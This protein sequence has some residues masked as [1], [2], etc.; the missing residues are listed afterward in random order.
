MDPVLLSY[1]LN[2]AGS[3]LSGRKNRQAQSEIFNTRMAD[4]QRKFSAGM[5]ALTFAMSPQGP[6]GVQQQN[7][8]SA[9]GL[10]QAEQDRRAREAAARQEI[11]RQAIQKAGIENFNK[12]VAGEVSK[13]RSRF[14]AAFADSTARGDQQLGKGV[15]GRLSKTFTKSVKKQTKGVANAYDRSAGQNS[16]I[17]GTVGG[18]SDVFKQVGAS[19]DQLAMLGVTDANARRHAY[20]Q[21]QLAALSGRN[22]MNIANIGTRAAG[23]IRPSPLT[24]INPNSNI[25]D[26]LSGVGNGLMFMALN[27]Y[28]PKWVQALGRGQ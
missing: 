25:G 23:T 7:M 4:Q 15:K 12:Q 17:G 3:F 2:G 14:A 6:M 24:T 28:N 13:K 5:N 8:D 21:M 9:Y 20:E 27:G 26:V 22:A 10:Q 11:L 1:L 16:V 19:G 18:Q